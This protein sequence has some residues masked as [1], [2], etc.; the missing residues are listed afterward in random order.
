MSGSSVVETDV[1]LQNDI[2]ITDLAKVVVSHF[3]V[4]VV[5]KS[6][7]TIAVIGAKRV[8]VAIFLAQSFVGQAQNMVFSATCADEAGKQQ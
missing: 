4:F 8:S 3:L 2:V 1:L 5:L 7:G 6:V